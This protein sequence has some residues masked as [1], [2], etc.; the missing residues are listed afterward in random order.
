[1][2]KRILNVWHIGAWNR[3]F[4]DWALCYHIHHLLNDLGAARDCHFHFHLVDA[5]RTYFYRE[6][7]DHMNDEADLVIY[8]GGGGVFH[9]PE[10]RSQS[11]W[12]FNISLE[13]L[14]RIAAPI[15][16]YSI[17]YNRFPYDPTEF[18]DITH[19]HLQRLQEKAVLFSSRNSGSRKVMSETFGLR[20][21]K[22]D[23]VPD[24]G[25]CLYD[26]PIEL[27][28]RRS[29]VPVIAVNLSGD[30]P[31]Y[32][33]PAPHEENMRRFFGGVKA[34]LLRC[35]KEL[36]AQIMF[37]PHLV[38]VDTD[39]YAEFA[40]GFPAGS[41]FSTYEELPFLYPPPGELMY[42]HV[43][44]FTNLFRQAD[45]MLGM[46]GHACII[47]FGAGTRFMPLGEHRKVG[48]FAADVG[49]PPEYAI[50]TMNDTEASV[51]LVFKKI[52][53]CLEDESYRSVIAQSLDRHLATLR[54]FNERV[55]DVVTAPVAAR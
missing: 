40:E 1:V 22:I 17:G 10:D 5:Q 26:R 15:V 9:R 46:R 50:R 39:L 19:V 31:H 34:A 6:L 53:S 36:G 25:I 23:L 45:V 35:V 32:R 24:P 33:Y 47:A 54:S 30:R 2:K 13:D 27:P 41:I 37:L 12:M 49:V 20:A 38:N 55:L 11:G 42:P 21:D 52:R 51:D 18:P 3:N 16:V 28:A 14:D 48:Y 43:P 4:G 7:V 29:G 8:G 44:F